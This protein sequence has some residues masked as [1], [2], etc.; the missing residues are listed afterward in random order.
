MKTITTM[1][2]MLEE[3]KVEMKSVRAASSAALR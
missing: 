3:A 1:V 2:K